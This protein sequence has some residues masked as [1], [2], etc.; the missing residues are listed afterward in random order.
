MKINKK[1][2]NQIIQRLQKVDPLD[3]VSKALMLF[4]A[5]AILSATIKV[6]FAWG[7]F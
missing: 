2:L 3:A 6:I 5:L 1:K 4:V 7:R